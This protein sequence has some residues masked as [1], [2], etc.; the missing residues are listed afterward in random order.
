MCFSVIFLFDWV[1]KNN[2]L[3]TQLPT[4]SVNI[5]TGMWLWTMCICVCS[6][7]TQGATT[8]FSWSTPWCCTW[9]RRPS[10]TSTARAS[11]PAW[12]P[13]PHPPTWT[14]SRTWLSTWTLRVRVVIVSVVCIRECSKET[15]TAIS[16]QLCFVCVCVCVCVWI[17]GEA[18][19][20]VS[21]DQTCLLVQFGRILYTSIFSV[22]KYENC[23]KN[24]I[25]NFFNIFCSLF[26]TS[27]E[28]AQFW[29]FS[30]TCV[31]VT[32]SRTCSVGFC[33]ALCV[34][35]ALKFWAVQSEACSST[36]EYEC[37]SFL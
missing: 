28:C 18:N 19:L 21:L 15:S 27:L 26:V 3:L 33:I 17:E 11:R 24:T 1:Q 30:A 14:S 36:A 5:C 7:Q 9:E 10:S 37:T 35:P 20:A 31:S 16:V 2:K 29:V 32:T 23:P 22:R 12:T 6:R 13:S 8:T 25:I 4:G 34:V